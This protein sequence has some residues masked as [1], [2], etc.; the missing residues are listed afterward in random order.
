MIKKDRE[1]KDRQ[2]II[3][4]MK[5]CTVCRIAL[6]DNGYPYILPLNFGMAVDNEKIELFFH[7]ALIGHKLDLIHKDNRAGFEMDGAHKLQ[8][9]KEQGYCTYDYES[10]IGKGRIIIL[11]EEEKQEALQLLMD[12][13]H[14]EKK[15][16]FNP[17]AI[18]RTTVYKLTVEEV[19]GK[20]KEAKRA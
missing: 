16:G 5:R 10:I 20:R 12:H 15:A 2:E 6:N 4:V 3:E 14:P 11:S 17:A 1:I 9:F 7:S 8:Y 13:Y 18:P 19:T